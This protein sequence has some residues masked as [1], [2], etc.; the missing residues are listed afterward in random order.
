MI[1]QRVI[2]I[3]KI[4]VMILLTTR[5]TYEKLN[6]YSTKVISRHMIQG[7]RFTEAYVQYGL[8]NV[9]IK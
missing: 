1:V 4:P 2:R 5:L 6:L 7:C 3:M 8:P 9:K